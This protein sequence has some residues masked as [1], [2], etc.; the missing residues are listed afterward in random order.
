MTVLPFTHL[1]LLDTCSVFGA[2]EAEW[3]WPST[4]SQ[5][6]ESFYSGGRDLGISILVLLV[7][8]SSDSSLLS[9]SSLSYLLNVKALN[10]VLMSPRLW[11]FSAVWSPNRTD[12]SSSGRNTL[13]SNRC[14]VFYGRTISAPI[15]GIKPCNFIELLCCTYSLMRDSPCH[16][17]PQHGLADEL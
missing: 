3:T 14:F 9:L 6:S 2:E 15:W 4:K 5:P 11:G 10:E 7:T 16:P 8:F 13:L 12:M 1:T 17:H